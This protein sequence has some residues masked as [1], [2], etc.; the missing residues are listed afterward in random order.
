MTVVVVRNARVWVQ[1]RLFEGGVRI[2]DGT[3]A[4]LEAHP[5][6]RGNADRR[7]VLRDSRDRP[8]SEADRKAHCLLR[9]AGLTLS[10]QPC[11][12]DR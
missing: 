3:I 5:G 2:E 4:S 10:D 12:P 11:D 1:N 6:R 8:W 7:E 9:D